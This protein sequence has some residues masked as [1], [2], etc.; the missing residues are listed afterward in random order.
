MATKNGTTGTTKGTNGREVPLAGAYL[1]PCSTCGGRVMHPNPDERCRC[2]EPAAAVGPSVGPEAPEPPQ[3]APVRHA[4]IVELAQRL[5]RGRNTIR[6]WYVA[7]K[8]PAP[9]YC[10][11]LRCWYL[12][13]IEGWERARPVANPAPR[14]VTR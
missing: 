2:G 6:D 9:H 7:G 8:F 3:A 11:P 5:G 1:A 12:S 13:E 10:G 14:R 4:G